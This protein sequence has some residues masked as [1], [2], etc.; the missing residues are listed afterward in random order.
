M[1]DNK[2]DTS[3]DT[4][5]IEMPSIMLND[6]PLGK[7]LANAR[8]Q[9][10]A[11]QSDASLKAGV[12]AYYLR[13][14]ENDDFSAIAD[15]LY[16]LPFLRRYAIFLELDPEEVAGRFIRDVQRSDMNATR[17]SEPMAMIEHNSR[18]ELLR[19]VLIGAAA[20]V[21]LMTLWIGL[22]HLFGARSEEPAP[23]S[24]AAPSVKAT[25]AARAAAPSPPARNR[26]RRPLPPSDSEEE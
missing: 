1:A 19:R 3:R 5:P 8:E 21:V 18:S 17:M 24:S 4:R 11:S 15:Q 14:I 22:R 6:L 9:R 23:V 25:P 10:G 12:P 16:L 13:M 7:I 2:P 20:L 26:P